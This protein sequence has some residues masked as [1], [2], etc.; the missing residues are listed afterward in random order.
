MIGT[1]TVLL[2]LA[3][4]APV[5]NC[6]A[7]VAKHGAH[8]TAAAAVAAAATPTAARRPRRAQR[9]PPHRRKPQHPLGNLS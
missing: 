8:E 1:I 2:A 4:L 7:D 5:G 6:H 3:L 9:R